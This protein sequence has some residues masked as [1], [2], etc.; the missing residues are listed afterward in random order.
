MTTTTAVPCGFCGGAGPKLDVQEIDLV[1]YG[2][3]WQHH[4]P[5]CR[6]CRVQLNRQWRACAC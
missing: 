3:V 2:G 4:G 1:R 5:R 6:D